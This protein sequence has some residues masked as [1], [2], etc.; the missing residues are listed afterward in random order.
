MS[1]FCV[2]ILKIFHS[3]K[4]D[5][6]SFVDNGNKADR[7]KEEYIFPFAYQ[8]FRMKYKNM[9]SI[10]SKYQDYTTAKVLLR[11]RQG[12]IYPM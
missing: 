1:F 7:V 12:P 5:S 10:I 11:G 2:T 3:V 8:L 9:F 6:T 4:N